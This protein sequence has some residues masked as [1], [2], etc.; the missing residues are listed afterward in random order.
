MYGFICVSIFVLVFGYMIYQLIASTHSTKE[1]KALLAKAIERSRQ[2]QAAKRKMY[3]RDKRH[4]NLCRAQDNLF[5]T[6]LTDY[7][8]P[9]EFS[10]FKRIEDGMLDYE[11]MWKIVELVEKRRDKR[12]D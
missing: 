4:V 10:N 9:V 5:P 11:H 7:L 6:L 3:I 8:T 12:P 1:E 2:L